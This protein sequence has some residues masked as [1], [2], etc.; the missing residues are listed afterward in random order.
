VENVSIEPPEN[1]VTREGFRAVNAS[2]A[3]APLRAVFCA[4]P[5]TPRRAVPTAHRKRNRDSL[6][7]PSDRNAEMLRPSSRT[8]ARKKGFKKATDADEAR[9][10]REEGMIQIRKDKREE[11]MLKK[12][13]FAS[14][15]P[16]GG[17]QLSRVRVDA[18][19]EA[20]PRRVDDAVARAVASA[21]AWCPVFS[22]SRARGSFTRPDLPA[23]IATRG[24]PARVATP[25]R[26]PTTDASFLLLPRAET[27]WA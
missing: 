4:S 19:S 26:D 27:A 22:K 13:R 6:R 3:P 10:K 11:A 16:R 23:P 5:V 20:T 12:R 21:R 17:S 25:P 15:S 14:R 2:R 9:R 8:E 1:P 24:P 7:P 18:R